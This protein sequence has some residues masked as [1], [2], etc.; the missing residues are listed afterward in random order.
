MNAT[1]QMAALAESIESQVAGSTTELTDFPGGG[2]ML[3]VRLGGRLFVMS[4]A[5]DHGF[6]VDEV[7]ADDGFVTGYQ[8]VQSDFAPAADQLRGLIADAENGELPAVCLNFVV[9]YSRDM[10]AAK[11]FYERLGLTFKRE[12]HGSGPGHYA[13]ELGATVFEI[14]PC[15]GESSSA[16]RLGFHLPSV[17]RTVDRL[18][19][20]NVK[21]HS[22]PKDSPWGRRAVVEDP[23]GNRVELVQPVY[24]E[25]SARP[26]TAAIGRAG[27]SL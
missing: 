16:T 22:P 15:Q 5:P 21:I 27:N 13:A 14:Y 25:S 23:D 17:D 7:Q 10:E 6:G 11:T 2:A 3:D 1:S 24:D 26:T 8:F 18:R 19:N 9:V 12:K 4:Y 20:H